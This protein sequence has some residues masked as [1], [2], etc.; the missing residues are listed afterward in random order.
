MPAVSVRQANQLERV[1]PQR[2]KAAANRTV[3]TLV[4]D[5]L[6]KQV[7]DNVE[8]TINDLKA[9]DAEAIESA[10]IDSRHVD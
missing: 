10:R 6:A 3:T 1:T 5:D 4:R 7:R 8:K 9:G 2:I